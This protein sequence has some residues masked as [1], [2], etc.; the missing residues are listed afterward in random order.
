MKI[1]IIKKRIA[2]KAW[3]QHLHDVRIRNSGK[4]YAKNH[5]GI[6]RKDLGEINLAKYS[7]LEYNKRL[8]K[9]FEQYIKDFTPIHAPEN[10][11]VVDNPE[12]FVDFVNKI[13]VN[14]E[15]RQKVFI[16]MDK[17]ENITDEAIVVLL[18]NMIRFRE[19]K[20]DFNG[21]KPLKKEV[22]RKLEA[23]G[24]FRLLYSKGK[25]NEYSVQNIKS[26]IYTHAHK[27]VDS[28]I[29][30][31]L[32]EA[33][34]EF[35]WNE[36]RRCPG[37]RNSFMELM[38]N[39]FKHSSDSNRKHHWWVS[40]AKDYEKRTVTFGFVDYGLG[41][42]RSLKNKKPDDNLYGALD[43]LLIRFPWIKSDAETMKL[44]LE[45]ELHRTVTQKRNHGKG[46]PSLYQCMQ[47]NDFDNLVIITNNVYVNVK[48]EK[49]I[50]LN[51]EF[52][53]T[54]VS[55]ELTPSIMSLKNTII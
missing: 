49:Y 2:R 54:F 8:K 16:V 42:F 43:R 50:M 6:S 22:R 1:D 5:Q 33:A 27:R 41:V 11:S 23:S 9:A 37:V 52:L 3:K 14:Y 45:G 26:T 13:R 7:P 18:S 19:D 28:G 55:W 40:M 15:V 36:K 46:L 4:E 44:I 53:G 17:I 25:G 21:N 34:S 10:F 48:K 12:E 30:T 39:T 47:R 35:L 51:T 31:K 38:S 20:I 24:F 32:V 29:A